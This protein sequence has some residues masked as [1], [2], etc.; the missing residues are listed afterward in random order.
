M[1]LVTNIGGEGSDINTHI[2]VISVIDIILGALTAL[3][4]L[5]LFFA[6]VAGSVSFAE[7]SAANTI[8]VAGIFASLFLIAIGILG[9]IVGIKLADHESWA[10][11][12]QIIF[13]I[14]QLFN[15]PLGTAFGI[16]SL[17]AMFSGDGRDLFEY[18]PE[19]ETRRAA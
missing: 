11:I 16:Y 7:T 18:H 12:V 5:I 17:W 15:F 19:E 8:L 9:I 13:G 6:L 10:R 4:G 14:F 1:N 2:R 3:G